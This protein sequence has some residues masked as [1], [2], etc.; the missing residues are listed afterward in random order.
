MGTILTRPVP[1]PVTGS[2]AFGIHNRHLGGA[3]LALSKGVEG[4]LYKD[5]FATE[6]SSDWEALSGSIWTW[7]E[8]GWVRAPA[9]G[10]TGLKESV[11]AARNTS[12]MCF[13]Y[14]RNLVGGA[15]ISLRRRHDGQEDAYF[16]QPQEGMTRFTRRLNDGDLILDSSGL[17]NPDATIMR[18]NMYV[19]D[20]DQRTWRN[21]SVRA[22]E[23]N[24]DLNGIVGVPCFAAWS[25]WVEFSNFIY[26]RE[27][28]M[29][30]TGLDSGSGQKFKVL[31]TGESVIIEAAE[32]SGTA[33]VSFGG[34]DIPQI[35][36]PNTIVTNA[37]DTELYRLSGA[38][39]PGS[40]YVLA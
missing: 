26:M 20:G 2:P 23:T 17:G 38:H 22:V 19:A 33:T 39:Y 4:L 21:G 40:T 11:V 14:R 29:V 12:F 7:Q 18:Y 13:K 24:T 28:T 3:G 6:V 36:Y 35:G 15:N 32:S 34:A 31:D 5:D 9:V 27:R 30:C 16:H 37:G 25:D 8:A 10:K 1:Y